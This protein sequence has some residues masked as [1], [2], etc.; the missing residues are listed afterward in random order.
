MQDNLYQTVVD[1]SIGKRTKLW[2]YIN[3]Y[4]CTI[5]DDCL[6]GTFVE[7]QK[8]VRIGN[9]VRVQSHSFICDGVTIEDDVFVGHHVVFI[10]DKYPRAVNSKGDPI[11]PADWKLYPIVVKKGAS[12]GS[13]ATILAG[14][15]IG[16]YAMVGAGSVVTKDVPANATVFGNPAKIKEK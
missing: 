9:K 15:T 7:I 13:N 14:V 10:N 12:I 6:I 1:C 8:G 2:G 3:L 11:T 4:G 16:E 5:G